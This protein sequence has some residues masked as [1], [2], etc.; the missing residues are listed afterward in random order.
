M[1]ALRPALLALT[2]GSFG[3]GVTEFVIMGLLL[4]VGADLDVSVSTAGLLISGYALGVVVGAPLLTLAVDRWPHRRALL[5]LMAIFT[6]G[7]LGCALAPT[8]G[9]LMLARVVTALAHGTYFGI[10]SIVAASVAPPERKA[11]AIALMFTGLTAANIAGVPFGTWLGHAYGWRTTFLAV[12][13]IGVIALAVIAR[14]VPHAQGR[15]AVLSAGAELRGLMQTPIVLALAT[16][17]LGYAGVF[18]TLTFI[19][20][21]MTQISG[22][23]EADISPILILF[24]GGLVI[25]NVI[26]GRLADK[27]VH[28][29]IYA[30]LFAL[31]GVNVLLG[32]FL[33]SPSLTLGLVALLGCAAF[34]TVAP[35]QI[36]IIDKTRGS[37]QNLVS[38]FNIAGFNLGNA[39]GAYIGG[40]VLD[41]GPGLAAIPYV[42]A[43]F[44]CLAVLSSLASNREESFVDAISEKQRKS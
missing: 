25:G 4:D 11:S 43:V 20:P 27:S 6:I 36:W 10:G 21:L 38:S 31:A 39:I 24:G 2:V 34:A 3:I 41:A 15:A 44:P 32:G 7:N 19:A 18:T 42:A 9:L 26:G 40:L 35:L 16:T 8:Y 30:S 5:T 1:W 37:S 13:A 33:H 14:H 29:A 22:F 17:V 12:A 28:L 23:A